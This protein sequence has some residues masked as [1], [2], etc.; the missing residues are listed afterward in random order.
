M[1]FNNYQKTYGPSS[2]IA[3]QSLGTM[4]FMRGDYVPVYRM[5]S[6]NKKQ[7]PMSGIEPMS[8]LLDFL[9]KEK[10]QERKGKRQDKREDRGTP[11]LDWF[12]NQS[13]DLSSKASAPKTFSN[14][15]TVGLPITKPLLV[16]PSS[17][18]SSSGSE[19]PYG[20]LIGAGVIGVGAFVIYQLR[21]K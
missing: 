16:S 13:S 1:L 7:N 8:G 17:S 18:D 15:S 20:F 5:V 6:S 9:S 10:R 12:K 19:I 21:K 11:I 4:P 3:P 2:W 14:K